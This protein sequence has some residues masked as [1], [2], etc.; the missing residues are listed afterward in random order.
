M[1]W[2]SQLKWKEWKSDIWQWHH[3]SFY[4]FYVDHCIHSHFPGC[5]DSDVFPL[6]FLQCELFLQ[7]PPM[8]LFAVSSPPSVRSLKYS[9]PLSSLVL[10]R[11]TVLVTLLNVL[12]VII[13][14]YLTIQ[15]PSPIERRCWR[16]VCT[17]G[18]GS[19][20]FVRCAPTQRPGCWTRP[21]AGCL[22]GRWGRPPLL[23]DG[24]SPYLCLLVDIRSCRSLHALACFLFH[25]VF[26]WQR[27]C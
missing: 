23:K 20:L 14:S 19:P 25:V 5:I 6:A 9:Y 11:M 1:F 18:R 7:K 27:Y 26:H 21:S 22:L 24:I 8:L 16:T 4:F 3:K 13:I 10:D 17:G 2:P 15:P 12:E